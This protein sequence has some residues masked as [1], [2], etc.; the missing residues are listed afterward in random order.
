MQAWISV[1]ELSAYS[2]FPKGHLLAVLTAYFDGCGKSHDPSTPFLTLV[3]YAAEAIVWPG[4]E[5]AWAKAL[6]DHKVDCLHFKDP[7]IRENPLL[8][9]VLLETIE[10]GGRFGM[11]SVS[12]S[13]NLAEHRKVSTERPGRVCAEGCINTLLSEAP[14][15]SCFF[16][17]NEEFFEEV[18]NPWENESERWPQLANITELGLVRSRDFPGVQAADW[19]GW[20]INRALTRRD[21]DVDLALLENRANHRAIIKP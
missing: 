2:S 4:F 5:A 9:G 3:G 8:V 12:C 13:V 10:C 19:L 16:D 17:R 11:H 7:A 1:S 21:Y 6:A 20:Y 15:M 18:K 14:S